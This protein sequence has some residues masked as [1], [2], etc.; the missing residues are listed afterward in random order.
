MLTT[1]VSTRRREDCGHINCGSFLML[2]T[3]G[4]LRNNTRYDVR[5]RNDQSSSGTFRTILM[6]EAMVINL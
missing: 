1:W 4:W 5:F 2:V 6:P 3:H